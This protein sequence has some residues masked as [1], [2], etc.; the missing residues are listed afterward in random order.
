MNQRLLETMGCI[1]NDPAMV[2]LINFPEAYYHDPEKRVLYSCPE[3]AYKEV[4][5]DDLIVCIPKSWALSKDQ[6]ASVRYCK[7]TNGLFRNKAIR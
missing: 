7:T 3:L 4:F 5:R 6:I 1:K 2:G